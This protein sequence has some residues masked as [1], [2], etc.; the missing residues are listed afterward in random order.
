MTDLNWSVDMTI[1]LKPFE[2]VIF[3]AITMI[4][5]VILVM[6]YR[7]PALTI[8]ASATH[9]KHSNNWKSKHLNK[10]KSVQ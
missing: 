5:Y 4:F 6:D 2:S 10:S 7:S 1:E 3:T 9:H 8:L